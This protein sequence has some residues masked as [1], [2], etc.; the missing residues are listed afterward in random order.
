MQLTTP[1][2]KITTS[3]PFYALAGVSDHAFELGREYAGTAA[4]KIN[5]FYDDLTVR[6]RRIVSRV[7]GQA[8][9]ELEDVSETAEQAEVREAP[10]REPARRTTTSKQ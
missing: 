2:K 4:A 6:G 8:A 5:E 10:G 7:S 3:K 9:H 1:V